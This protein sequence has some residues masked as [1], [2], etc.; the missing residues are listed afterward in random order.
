MK[1]TAPL[2]VEAE[3][4]PHASQSR[5]LEIPVHSAVAGEKVRHFYVHVPFCIRKCPYCAFYS[6]E[7][8]ELV[9]DRC[10]ETMAREIRDLAGELAPAT[11]FIGGGTPSMLNERQ[12][13]ALFSVFERSGWA[14]IKEWT[15]EANPA[16]LSL[17]KAK[18]LRALGVNRISLGVQSLNDIILERL[19]RVHSRQDALESFDVLRRAGFENI[20]IDL[21]FGVP[22]Q[23][24]ADWERTL[25]ETLA[26]QSEHLS[27]YE[28][29]YEEDTEFL[30][31]V[32]AGRIEP[33]DD[34]ACDMYQALLDAATAHGMVQYEVSNFAR[35]RGQCPST[36]PSLSC[37]HNINYWRAGSYY[38]VGPSAASYVAGVRWVNVAD[39]GRYCEIV[40]S[41]HLPV[42]TAE[43]LSP[44]ASA[45]EAAAFGLRMN[46][47]WSF[48]EFKQIT[49]FDLRT[50]WADDMKAL[51]MQGLGFADTTGFR[52][53]SRGLRFADLA[54]E[55]FLRVHDAACA[56]HDH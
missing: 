27:A 24:L 36:P 38:G 15:V 39:F 52:L 19:G 37:L 23:T 11:V 7:A 34:L 12:I 5:E 50:E 28:L 3:R 53:T 45:G 21:I 43:R 33:D 6:L 56:D 20:N 29:T 32:R 4:T 18:L 17:P 26:L 35:H 22:G 16:T 44:L 9:I 31:A 55:R 48:A 10:L 8:S 1:P 13:Q 30:A 51:E 14:G 47:G 40:D 2:R 41:G 25:E 54:A 42:A 49:G 46:V